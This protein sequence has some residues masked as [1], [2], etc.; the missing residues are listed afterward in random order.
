MGVGVEAGPR[1]A[2]G[3][4]D[5]DTVA[6]RAATSAELTAAG[7]SEPAREA[8]MVADHLNGTDAQAVATA[9]VPRPGRAAAGA[10]QTRD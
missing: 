2:A 1:P 6:W 3:K 8:K 10:K 7:V 4:L 9:A 5:Y